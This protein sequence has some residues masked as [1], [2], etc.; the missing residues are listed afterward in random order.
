M[1]E[2][3]V[4]DCLHRLRWGRMLAMT[5]ERLG[6]VAM[7]VVRMVMVHG[8]LTPGDVM[9]VTSAEGDGQS[10]SSRIGLS[11]VSGLNRFGCAVDGLESMLM[12]CAIGMAAVQEATVELV[13]NG[14]LQPTCPE[15]HVIESDLIQRRFAVGSHS[16]PLTP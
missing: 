5:Q 4:L 7:E 1:Y 8:K 11:R 3:A 10:E 14:L 2:F 13:R 9:R 15:L 12:R 6:S 16:H